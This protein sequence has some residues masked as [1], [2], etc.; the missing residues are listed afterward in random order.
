MNSSFKTLIKPFHLGLDCRVVKYRNGKVRDA[1]LRSCGRDTSPADQIDSPEG[2]ADD[3]LLDS[4]ENDDG[5]QDEKPSE[6][7]NGLGKT[8]VGKGGRA[9]LALRV[10]AGH[11]K[12]EF[13]TSFA[14]VLVPKPSQTLQGSPVGPVNQVPDMGDPFSTQLLQR[15]EQ[16]FAEALLKAQPSGGWL[17]EGISTKI[18]RTVREFP[19]A[20]PEL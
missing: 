14:W 11:D 1:T 17:I 8:G 12:P 10:R 15:L 9:F 4:F 5:K 13:H 19:F 16:R 2:S 20:V 6:A 18:G 7:L 3:L